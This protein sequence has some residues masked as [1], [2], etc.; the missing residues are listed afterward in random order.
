M[1][2]ERLVVF[3]DILQSAASVPLQEDRINVDDDIADAQIDGPSSPA[4]GPGPGG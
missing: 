3:Q 4:D 2:C 1:H